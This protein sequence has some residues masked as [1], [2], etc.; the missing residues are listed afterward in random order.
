MSRTRRW[1]KSALS[2]CALGF[3][4]LVAQQPLVSAADLLR[5]VALTGDPAPGAEPGVALA[6]IRSIMPLGNGLASIGG[7]LAGP[8]I[9]VS[10]PGRNHSAIW[11]ETLGGLNMVVRH[12]DAALGAAEGDVFLGRLNPFQAG[13]GGIAFWADF[14][15]PPN[16]AVGTRNLGIWRQNAAG[17][18]ELVVFVPESL[19]AG[20]EEGITITGLNAWVGN[21]SGKIAYSGA[22]RE[23]ADPA[24]L[25][26]GVWTQGAGGAVRLVVRSG[27][28][29][30]GMENAVVNLGVNNLQLSDASRLAF[31]AEVRQYDS[32]D[33]VGPFSRR[34]ALLTENGAGLLE[35]VAIQGQPAPGASDGALFEKFAFPE[36]NVVLSR[37]G[38]MAFYATLSG[39]N[40]SDGN[41]RG[42]WTDR[43]GVV[44][45]IARAGDSPA[46]IDADFRWY[47]FGNLGIN[48][49]GEIA[50]SANYTRE[51][52]NQV[53]GNGAWI[54]QQ[55][56]LQLVA[57][58]GDLLP[59]L[60]E[61]SFFH[62]GQIHRPADYPVAVLVARLAGAGVDDSNDQGIWV[63]NAWGEMLLV[64]REGELLDVSDDPHAPDLRR[65]ST[66]QFGGIDEQGYVSFQATFVGGSSG[67]FVSSIV[68]VPEPSPGTLLLL[69]AALLGSAPRRCHS[70]RRGGAS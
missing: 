70:P 53:V 31:P 61:D 60:P 39:N 64:A 69:G 3:S 32:P 7:T 25:N 19:T 15:G 59:G 4:L 52:N 67:A 51:G 44:S 56:Q 10:L 38:T 36:G 48:D 20:G 21:G 30:S 50:F 11:S 65:V 47:G 9:E 13:A 66:L 1:P 58:T 16:I 24:S 2:A 14:V 5:T 18:L 22:Y 37:H 45:L 23:A 62:F 68:A 40:V 29:V 8:G 63:R 12:G 41:S 17:G 26:R 46:G 43:T 33:L 55:G 34:N 49:S 28:P 35:A 6:F 42:V 27:D 57:K 54:E